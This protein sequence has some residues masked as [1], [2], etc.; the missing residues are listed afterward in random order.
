MG[1]AS[2]RRK[3]CSSWWLQV[4]RCSLRIAISCRAPPILGADKF[5][6]EAIDGEA[7]LTLFNGKKTL[8]SL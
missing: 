7:L 3:F 5:V 6:E 1:A 8:G 2:T 4:E